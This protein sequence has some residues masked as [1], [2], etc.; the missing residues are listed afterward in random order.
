MRNKDSIFF[1]ATILVISFLIT[2]YTLSQTVWGI[3][4]YNTVS[5]VNL[6]DKEMS[7]NYEDNANTLNLFDSVFVRNSGDI[8]FS[9]KSENSDFAK[10]LDYQEYQSKLFIYVNSSIVSYCFF[11]ADVTAIYYDTLNDSRDYEDLK[12]L[13]TEPTSFYEASVNWNV[14]EYIYPGRYSSTFLPGELGGKRLIGFYPISCTSLS[15]IEA[16]DQIIN[17]YKN[18]DPAKEREYLNSRLNELKI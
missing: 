3:K 18:L 8:N 17:S 7:F 12:I 16:I 5:V 10:Q 2:T 1:W 4:F 14:N 13:S 6:D 9:V 11:S 15:R